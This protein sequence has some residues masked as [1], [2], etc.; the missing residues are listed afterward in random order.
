MKGQ[1][2]PGNTNQGPSASLSMMQQCV[3]KEASQLLCEAVQAT[4]EDGDTHEEWQ[5]NEGRRYVLITGGNL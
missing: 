4:V 1:G 2:G 3:N 5:D